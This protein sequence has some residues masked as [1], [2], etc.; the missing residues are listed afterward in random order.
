MSFLLCV[1][2]AMICLNNADFFNDTEWNTAIKTIYD[3]TTGNCDESV[4]LEDVTLTMNECTIV[5]N[6]DSN[7]SKLMEC[8]NGYYIRN[9]NYATSDC[10]GDYTTT[11]DG[12]NENECYEIA[13]NAIS[14]DCVRDPCDYKCTSRSDASCSFDC[15]DSVWYVI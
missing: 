5:V 11:Y 1:I 3:G 15:C 13:C 8:V 2:V 12:L 9:I 10:S 4:I 6:A 14:C 7:S